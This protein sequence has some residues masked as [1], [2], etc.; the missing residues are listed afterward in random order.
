[1]V[2]G[3]GHSRHG[4]LRSACS[5]WKH[6][7]DPHTKVE[8]KL[9]VFKT[10]ACYQP[11]R[12]DRS[13]TASM[14]GCPVH[15]CCSSRELHKHTPAAKAGGAGQ[16]E[17]GAA[18][19]SPRC[20]AIVQKGSRAVPVAIG[21]IQSDRAH[22]GKERIRT[23]EEWSSLGL[24]REH[25]QVALFVHPDRVYAAM[26][27]PA[28]VRHCNGPSQPSCLPQSE[29]A[30]AMQRTCR[31]TLKST[32]WLQHARPGR[33]LGGNRAHDSTDGVVELAGRMP[34]TVLDRRQRPSSS[35]HRGGEHGGPCISER[36]CRRSAVLSTLRR[37]P[38]APVISE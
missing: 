16:T 36:R 24:H 13:H 5:P 9:P 1:M 30:K 33:A 2:A 19:Q 20:P 15:C 22:T 17:E 6:T 37:Q 8:P 27:A 21:L 18:L 3:T 31:F 25:G 11:H 38:A 32:M 14:R 34:S 12:R 26:R 35:T 10:T 4:S 29:A 23:G 7:T 28:A